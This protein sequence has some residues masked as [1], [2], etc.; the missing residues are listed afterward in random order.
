MAFSL[1]RRPDTTGTLM[2][3]RSHSSM[4][5]C[6]AEK[7]MAS[8]IACSIVVPAGNSAFRIIMLNLLSFYSLSH[9]LEI[10]GFFTGTGFSGVSSYDTQTG[11]FL[12]LTNDDASNMK[13]C[14]S[15]SQKND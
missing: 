14:R 2:S 4:Q 13:I 7:S 12:R 9:K 8:V 5:P 1:G 11:S 15:M 3:F 10:S 6:S